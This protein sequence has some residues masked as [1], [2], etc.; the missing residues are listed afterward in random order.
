MLIE[1]W[2]RE[3]LED[4]Q[5]ILGIIGMLG[6]SNTFDRIK[7]TLSQKLRE[8]VKREILEAIEEFKDT[9]NNPYSSI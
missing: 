4:T 6:L 9:A 2:N 1:L 7:A 3:S 8:D 5:A